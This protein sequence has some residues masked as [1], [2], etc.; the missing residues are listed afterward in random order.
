LDVLK[1]RFAR[2][3]IDQKEFEEKSR[4]GKEIIIFF[5]HGPNCN[6]FKK[7]GAIMPDK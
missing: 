4:F 5:E 2:G 7:Q 3:E 1:G 6:P